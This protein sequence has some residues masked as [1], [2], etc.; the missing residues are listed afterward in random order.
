MSNLLLNV[1]RGMPLI[2]GHTIIRTGPTPP[3][4]RVSINRLR[5]SSQE[6]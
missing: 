5:T 1:I 6:Q 3:I 2:S 4:L